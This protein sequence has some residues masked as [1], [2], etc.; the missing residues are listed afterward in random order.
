MTTAAATPA[1][2]EWLLPTGLIALSLVP[3]AA[4][5]FRVTQLSVGAEVT[6]DNARF[7][8]TP[9]PVIVH[10]VGA[11]V[12]CILGAFQFAAGLRRRRPGWHRAAGRLLV[13]CGLAAALSGIW[14]TLF[15]D[16]PAGDRGLLTGFRLVF[17]SAMVVAVGLGFAAILRRDIVH[18]RMWMIRGYAIGQGAGTQFVL[19]A[20]WALAIGPPERL[21]RAVLH[22]A[23]WVLNL[24]VAESIIRRRWR[25]ARRLRPAGAR[26]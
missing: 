22:L 23:A 18:H 11:S 3:V 25:P 2:R 8:A 20:S 1:N 4:G 13:P 17:G 21:S 12:F 9:A 15:Y 7:F 6:E 14:M 19:L 16:L 10:I 26:R 5:A 24:V